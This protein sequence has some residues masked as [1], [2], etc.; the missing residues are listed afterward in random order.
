MG[1]QGTFGEIFHLGNFES[2]QTRTGEKGVLEFTW[3]KVKNQFCSFEMAGGCWILPLTWYRSKQ[4]LLSAGFIG[5]TQH[6]TLDFELRV[7]TSSINH[8]SLSSTHYTAARGDHHGTMK[9]TLDSFGL[10]A[11]VISTLFFY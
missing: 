5:N 7:L 1:T 9:Y 4:S 3:R 10:H 2:R 11:M 6:Q 8:S